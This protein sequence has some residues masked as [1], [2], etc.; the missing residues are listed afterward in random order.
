MFPS[1]DTHYA[2]VDEH[3]SRCATVANELNRQI[4]AEGPAGR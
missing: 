3:A 1:G 4:A 2:G